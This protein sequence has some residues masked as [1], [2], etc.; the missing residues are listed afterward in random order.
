M[1]GDNIKKDS[2]NNT[3]QKCLQAADYKGCMN[4]QNR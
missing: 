3:H 1:I 2:N 4:Y